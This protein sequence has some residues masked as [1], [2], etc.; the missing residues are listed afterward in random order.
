MGKSLL[1]IVRSS[2]KRNNFL[3]QNSLMYMLK[4]NLDMAVT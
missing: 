1:I 3:Q 4:A 2:A